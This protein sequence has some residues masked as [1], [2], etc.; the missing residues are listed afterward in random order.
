MYFREK[1]CFPL[2]SDKLAFDSMNKTSTNIFFIIQAAKHWGDLAK[3]NP[4]QSLPQQ[5]LHTRGEDQQR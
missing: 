5:V 4:T 2:F 1:H 3:L